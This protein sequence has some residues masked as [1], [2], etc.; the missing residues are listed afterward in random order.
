MS[1]HRI[2]TTT[3]KLQ[4]IGRTQKAITH[5]PYGRWQNDNTDTEHT[6]IYPYVYRVWVLVPF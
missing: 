4:S 6:G 5:N 2:L 1:S 3:A